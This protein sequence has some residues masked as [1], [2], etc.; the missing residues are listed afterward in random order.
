[1]C[2]G[3]QASEDAEA[4]TLQHAGSSSSF[5]GGSAAMLGDMPGSSVWRADAPSQATQLKA[6]APLNVQD[7]PGPSISTENPRVGGRYNGDD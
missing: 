4:M 5:A 2:V 1:M 6:H 7:A 3:A